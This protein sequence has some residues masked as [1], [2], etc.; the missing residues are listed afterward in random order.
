MGFI[1]SPFPAFGIMKPAIANTRV[2]MNSYGQ[3]VF[4][5]VVDDG[6]AVGRPGDSH[7]A[8]WLH[9]LCARVAEQ[10]PQYG[11]FLSGLQIASRLSGILGV[12]VF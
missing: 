4:A 12:Q 2:D 5:D 6:Q 3:S 9:D 11:A 8:R 10:I 1:G 7:V